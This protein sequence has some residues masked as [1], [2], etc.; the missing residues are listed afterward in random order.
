[1]TWFDRSLGGKKEPQKTDKKPDMVQ[2]VSEPVTDES[3]P[4]PKL[5]GPCGAR[6]GWL[7]L[8][9]ESS[10]GSVDVSGVGQDRG[11]RGWGNP[12]SRHFDHRRAC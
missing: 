4:S 11:Q 12:V 2:P 3:T 1:M 9:R 7:P 10:N 6:A 5:T 8:Q